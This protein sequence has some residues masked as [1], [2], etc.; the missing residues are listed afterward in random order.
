M[1]V[2]AAELQREDRLCETDWDNTG[3]DIGGLKG[4]GQSDR[5]LLVVSSS[6]LVHT[7]NLA[8]TV[9]QYEVSFLPASSCPLQKDFCILSF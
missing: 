3:P 7:T 4:S 1:A 5:S 8:V 2:P 9:T 6:L